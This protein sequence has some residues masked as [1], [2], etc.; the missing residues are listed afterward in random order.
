MIAIKLIG[1]KQKM[2]DEIFFHNLYW[3]PSPLGLVQI[4]CNF[5]LIDSLHVTSLKYMFNIFLLLNTA[6]IEKKI[7][8]GSKFMKHPF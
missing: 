6:T 2:T 4:E 1:N 8:M 5:F 3:C 7:K